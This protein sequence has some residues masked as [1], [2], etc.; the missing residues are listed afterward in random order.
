M[1]V[2]VQAGTPWGQ[3]YAQLGLATNDVDAQGQ[4]KPA[5]PAVQLYDLAADAG[6]RQNVAGE[7]PAQAEAMSL[8]L[9]S[10]VG[11]RRAARPSGK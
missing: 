5:A 10:L 2:R 7:K 9:E 3:P 1:T 11:K 8:R 6:Q 4:V